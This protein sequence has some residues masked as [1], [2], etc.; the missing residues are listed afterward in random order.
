M[1]LVAVLLWQL[2][3]G[4]CVTLVLLA[5]LVLKIQMF[6]GMTPFR[7]LQTASD[8]YKYNKDGGSKLLRK[9]LKPQRKNTFMFINIAVKNFNP[10]IVILLSCFKS[11]IMFFTPMVNI[12]V[13]YRSDF[14]AFLPN[15]INSTERNAQK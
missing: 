15:A 2:Q 5:R 1:Q 9:D 4:D 14:P 10:T 6:R 11:T 8:W 13:M 7:L 12:A 3:E